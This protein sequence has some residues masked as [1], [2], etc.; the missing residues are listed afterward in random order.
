MPAQNA[1]APEPPMDAEMAWQCVNWH[2][3]ITSWYGEFTGRATESVVASRAAAK[4]VTAIAENA[5]QN[6]GLK[7]PDMRGELS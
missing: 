7:V 1:S 4:F 6:L 5:I 3:H 2:V